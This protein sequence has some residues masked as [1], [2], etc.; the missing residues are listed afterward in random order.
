MYDLGRLTEVVQPIVVNLFF[1]YGAYHTIL[2]N[3]P[4]STGN[5]SHS[6]HRA[7]NFSKALVKQIAMSVKHFKNQS[8][9]LPDNYSTQSFA[10][11]VRT[12]AFH[13]AQV[14]QK[15]FHFNLSEVDDL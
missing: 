2:E 11:E 12:R 9:F 1:P 3:T 15:Y 14:L 4:Q 7:A 6:F 8:I 10:L 13:F 5:I